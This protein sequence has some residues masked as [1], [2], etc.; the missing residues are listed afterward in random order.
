M[1]ENERQ[2]TVG[3]LAEATGVTV[4]TLHH[5]DEIAL[6]TPTSRSAAG[7]RRYAAADVRRLHRIAA[8]RGFGFTL[9]QIAGVLDSGETDVR[10]LVD[11]QLAQAED[12][13]AK[14]RRLC[15]SLR[16]VALALAVTNPSPEMFV[17]L[18][19]GMTAMENAYSREELEAMT[20]HRRRMTEQLTPE[21]FAAMAERRRA[22]FEQLTPEQIE[23]MRRARNGAG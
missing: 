16:S 4:R 2:W 9:A 1:D 3:E 14:V 6:L 10:A 22:M 7:H 18:I 15:A 8:L 23:A 5:Y 13:L 20:E 19:E 11:Q 12:R 17:Q 21:E